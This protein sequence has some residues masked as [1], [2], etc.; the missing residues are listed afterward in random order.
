M[1]DARGVLPRFTGD[2]VHNAWAP[3]AT[4]TS[5]THALRGA[6]VLREVT[7]VIDLAPARTF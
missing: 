2:A 5:A 4:S 3:Y 6:H 1:T 7:A